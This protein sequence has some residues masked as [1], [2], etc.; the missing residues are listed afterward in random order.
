VEFDGNDAIALV[1][2][3][4]V[5][6]DL[7]GVGINKR[8]QNYS[9]KPNATTASTYFNPGDWTASIY[10]VADGAASTSGDYLGAYFFE[11]AVPALVV[12]PASISDLSSAFGTASASQSYTLTGSNLTQ[13]VAVAVSS[14]DFQVS[15]NASTGFS[16]GLT[17][18]PVAGQL[19][20]TIFVRL[21]SS[22]KAGVVA[23]SISHLSG[24]ASIGL[25]LSGRVLSSESKAG[26]RTGMQFSVPN[27]GFVGQP[28]N[29]VVTVIED[30]SGSIA[31]LQGL[32]DSARVA[33]PE[34]FIL[35]RLRANTT[36]PVAGS[37]LILSSKMTLS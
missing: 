25:P 21:S 18:T 33:Q 11:A 12:S 19:L 30:T 8:D 4:G 24:S 28:I 23:G 17:L 7:F 29:E 6:I 13:T 20:Q 9:R 5:V 10:T 22:A 1:N 36:Y 35:V 26:L 16:S 2:T 14:A 37:P 27:S 32:I 15:T 31:T 34:Q 3:S